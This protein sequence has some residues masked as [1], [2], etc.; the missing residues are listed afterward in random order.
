MDFVD[1]LLI[2]AGAFSLLGG[3]LNWD[4]FMTG[5]RAQLIVKLFKRT[6]ARVFY[7]LL[8]IVLIVAGLLP[9][10]DVM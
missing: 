2:L 5:R 1:V 6:G 4:W 10:F 8:G 9:V 3:I 7:G